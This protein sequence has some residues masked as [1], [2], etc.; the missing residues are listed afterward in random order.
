[1]KSSI[2]YLG[3]EIDKYGICASSDN[4]RA[5]VEFQKPTSFKHLHS[6]LGLASYF[7]RFV[8]NSAL[9]T[10]PLYNLLR[11]EK[12]CTQ[13]VC[14]LEQ[15]DT[16]E[17]IKNILA[18]KPVLCIYSPLLATQLHCDGLASILIQKQSEGYFHPVLHYS[19]RTTDAESKY[20]SFELKA[21]CI[22]QPLERFRIYQQ[23][24]HFKILTDLIFENSLGIL[25]DKTK[26]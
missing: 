9:V 18:S 19:R 26:K 7:R 6:F 24:M 10:K 23:G 13:F 20:H 8:K 1:M 16:F 25:Q 2:T 22:V 4:V 14:G 12:H 21:L 5:L 17:K 11:Q 15:L 3:Y